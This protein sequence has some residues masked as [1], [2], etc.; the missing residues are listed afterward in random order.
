MRPNSLKLAL[1]TAPPRVACNCHELLK[2]L[3]ATGSRPTD[4][5]SGT[6]RHA[7]RS[8]PFSCPCTGLRS[9]TYRASPLAAPTWRSWMASISYGGVSPAGTPAL[10]VACREVEEEIEA[11]LWPGTR[12]A[13]GWIAGKRYRV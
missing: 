6:A 12:G 1:V 4:A 10:L 7:A 11:E 5:T 2:G 3:D 9:A 13:H 8:C